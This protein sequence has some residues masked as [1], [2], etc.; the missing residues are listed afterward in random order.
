MQM[1]QMYRDQQENLF[2]GTIQG[3]LAQ[4]A[5]DYQLEHTELVTRYLPVAGA[6]PVHNGDGIPAP[7]LVAV[8][9]EKQKKRV[10]KK[11]PDKVCCKGVTAKGQPC[12]FAALADGFCKK[13][14]DMNSKDPSAKK[15]PKPK[16]E[17]P[18]HTHL[19]EEEPTDD[20]P[21]CDT[22]GDVTQ[23]EMPRQDWE[24]KGAD[25]IKARLQKMLADAEEDESASLEEFGIE[26]E[27]LIAPEKEEEEAE[28]V[29]PTGI[30]TPEEEDEE[31][32]DMEAR[33]RKILS[34]DNSDDEEE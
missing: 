22:Q 26:A 32:D 33:L 28:E 21:V 34:E 30:L 13:H 14:S 31:D 7:L 16:A 10:I 3:L 5:Q 20:C 27:E 17:K 1:I 23:A 9:Q 18:R 12:K 4:I 25:E 19:T 6:T 29:T 11:N 2:R 24:V 8:Q 15:N